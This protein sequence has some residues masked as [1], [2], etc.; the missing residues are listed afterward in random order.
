M[1]PRRTL[2]HELPRWV[3]PAR[4]IWF[5]TICCKRRIEAQLT[6]PQNASEILQTVIHRHERGLWYAHLFLL[7]PD[8]AHGIFS[9]PQDGDAMEKIVE[10][11]KRWVARTTDVKWHRGFFDHRLRRDESFSEKANYV[12]ANP[13]RAGLVTR[14]EDWLHLWM[15][16]D[17][18]TGLHR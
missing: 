1:H 6:L 11:W 15:P 4:E 18:F 10:D 3:D 12:L 8:H 16:G 13:V 17:V 2:P 5:L 14:W 7:M 9:F